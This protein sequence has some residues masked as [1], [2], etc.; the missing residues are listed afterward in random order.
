MTST[1][2]SSI[3][4]KRPQES[5]SKITFFESSFLLLGS[6]I[7][8]LLLTSA[9]HE[10]GH[11]LALASISINFRLILNPFSA[12]MALP[13]SPLPTSSQLFVTL[14]GT[15]A[16]LLFGTLLTMTL[17]PSRSPRLVPLLMSAPIAFLS[18]SGYFLFGGIVAG[19]DVVLI[20]SA[21]VPAILIHSLGVLLMA[22]GAIL[23]FL[24]FPLLGIS[25]EHS[26]GKI[27]AILFI[28]MTSHGFGMI[29]F[30][31]LF[32][33]LEVYIAVA[34][35]ISL[36]LM[37]PFFIIAFKLG[38]SRLDSLQQTD[39]AQI[40]KSTVYLALGLAVVFI[41]VELIFFK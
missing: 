29:A 18:T 40:D 33:P 10:A 41:I 13:L 25:S 39:L 8:A 19:S 3:N 11:G 22:L 16:E 12:S 6:Y 1:N 28:G 32:N 37:I 15:V 35:V 14:A 9:A 30:A 2:R 21:G 24:L 31:L 20:I 4:D 36:S 7:I 38:F 17:W 26:F 34:N 23:F 5:L 27:F